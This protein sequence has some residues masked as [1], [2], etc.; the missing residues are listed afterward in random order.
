M[1]NPNWRPNWLERWGFRVPDPLEFT[2][3]SEEKLRDEKE[4]QEL[5]EKAL[6][7]RRE[8]GIGTEND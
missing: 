4:T 6:A 2:E 3:P 7:D 5:V 1:S 8:A